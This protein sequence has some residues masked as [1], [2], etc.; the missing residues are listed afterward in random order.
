MDTSTRGGSRAVRRRR[1]VTGLLTLG[2]ALGCGK[3]TTEPDPNP[4]PQPSQ[5]TA[6]IAAAGADLVVSAGLAVQLS[7]SGSDADGDPITYTWT[8]AAPSGSAS[9]LDQ[10]TSATPSFVPDVVGDYLA[11]LVVNDGTDDSPADAMTVTAEDNTSSQSVGAGGGEVVSSDGKLTLT[12]PAGALAADTEISVTGV[13]ESQM[14]ESLTELGGPTRAYDLQPSGLAFTAPIEVAFTLTEAVSLEAGRFELHGALLYSESEGVVELLSDLVLEPSEAEPTEVVARGSLGHFSYAAAVETP[15]LDFGVDGPASAEVLEPFDV[16]ITL[17]VTGAALGD[18]TGAVVEDLSTSP[19]ALVGDLS[20]TLNGT[21]TVRTIVNQYQC[22]EP[23]TG[24]FGALVEFDASDF[25]AFATVR[26]G[27]DIE[28]SSPPVDLIMAF[29]SARRA[30]YLLPVSGSPFHVTLGSGVRRYHAQTG[31]LA[32]DVQAIDDMTLRRQRVAALSDGTYVVY[33]GGPGMHV[34]LSADPMVVNDTLVEASKDQ[35]LDIRG[36]GS[37]AFALVSPYGDFGIVR[38][39]SATRSFSDALRNRMSFDIAQPDIHLRSIWAS[40]DQST[41]IG[42]ETT[43]DGNIFNDPA[44]VVLVQWNETAGTVETLP[45]VSTGAAVLDS[46]LGDA[47]R[48]PT[49]DCRDEGGGEFLCVLGSALTH[50]GYTAGETT[51]GGLMKIFRV[52]AVSGTATRLASQNQP[53]R[54][55]G[56]IVTAS[57]GT[58]RYA[59]F[60]NQGDSTLELWMINGSSFIAAP[61]ATFS[62][63]A[64][65]PEPIDMQV[66]G[67]GEKV[68]IACHADSE[69]D[70]GLLLIENLQEVIAGM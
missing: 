39:T 38:Y 41:V 15:G 5:N 14:P 56:G 1:V 53:A 68:V 30:D 66:L 61:T 59:L 69:A 7:G 47:F 26:L 34:D 13:T 29:T 67:D 19:V 36:F 40:P 28:C 42:I 65:C 9:T 23:G 58:G 49:L 33:G 51:T 62:I 55:A 52:D 2:L 57:D 4:D 31:V 54:V 32:P 48:P 43:G 70:Q 50:P 63:E 45:V 44:E 3:S 60:A 16:T 22:G 64:Q 10:V 8:L 35:P 11:T 24:K 21:G 37:D 27:L 6:P 18:I 46:K 17:D 12:I 25:T 20:S